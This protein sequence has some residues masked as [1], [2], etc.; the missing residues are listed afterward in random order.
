MR[1]YMRYY[2]LAMLSLT[3]SQASIARVMKDLFIAMPVSLM[4]MLDENARKD[5]V[6]ICLSGMTTSLPNE[7]GGTSALQKLTDNYLKLREDSEGTVVTDMAL[8]PRGKDTVVCVVRTL[9]TPQPVS[10]VQFFNS[11]WQELKADKLLKLPDMEEFPRSSD[12]LTEGVLPVEFMEATLDATEQGGI[13]LAF[14]TNTSKHRICFRWNG[15]KF[16][17]N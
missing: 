4:P 3:L 10:E 17:K 12:L 9:R 7:W 8:L 2:L 5:L 14:T 1:K 16:L 15:K 6:D 11:R 13:V